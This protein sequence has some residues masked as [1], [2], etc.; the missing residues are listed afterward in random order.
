[1]KYNKMGIHVKKNIDDFLNTVFGR[2]PKF[3]KTESR[4][5]NGVNLNENVGL[6]NQAK[7]A[8]LEA[9]AKKSQ[10]FELVRRFQNC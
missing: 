9:E 10:A 2:T 3:K 1:M 8:L 5:H 7:K 6:D 4:L